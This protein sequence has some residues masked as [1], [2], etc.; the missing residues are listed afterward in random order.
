MK[1]SSE[2]LTVILV[3]E[4]IS[5]G[6]PAISASSAYLSSSSASTFFDLINNF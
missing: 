1:A 4:S 6:T 3:L 2:I 5:T